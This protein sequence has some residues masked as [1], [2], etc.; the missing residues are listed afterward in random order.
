MD[1]TI[2]LKE[3]MGDTSDKIISHIK[4]I[5]KSLNESP[6]QAKRDYLKELK[7]DLDKILWKEKREFNH[8][9]ANHIKSKI[10][11]FVNSEDKE[12]ELTYYPIIKYENLFKALG[13]SWD[14]NDW[15]TNGWE[16]DF[17]QDVFLEGKKFIFTGSFWYGDFK[18]V[19]EYEEETNS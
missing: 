15:D 1:K 9:T 10:E 8:V 5:E 18:L 14:N 4:F 17:W 2:V 13:F 3:L 12:V 6:S 7:E 16:I 11:K 19:K